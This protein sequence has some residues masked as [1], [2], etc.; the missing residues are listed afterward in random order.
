MP[1]SEIKQRVD[2]AVKDAMRAREK[3]R[4]GALRLI[5]AEI[6]RIEIDER[7]EL[8]DERVLAILDNM[9]THRHDSLTI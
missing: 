2:T 7:I 4:L 9:L 8:D 6:K 1:T 5:M 3:Q